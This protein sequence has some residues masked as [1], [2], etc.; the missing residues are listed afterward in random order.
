[1]SRFWVGLTGGIGSGKTTVANLFVQQGVVVVDTDV[2]AHQLTVAGG[3]AM[4]QI[5]AHFGPAL[6]DR[7]GALDRAAMRR[8][9]FGD[10]AQR[11]RLEDILH[12]MIARQTL[13]ACAS[14][15]SP[16][17]IV[18]VPL[19][20]EVRGWKEHFDRVLVIDCEEQQQIER[21]KARN[22]LSENEVRAI[23]A[24]QVSRQER[25][26]AAD[27]ILINSQGVAELEDQV[28]RLHALYLELAQKKLEA[29]C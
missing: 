27:D 29:E 25:L 10:P 17:V 20:L 8:L 16:Y 23:L 12:P 26:G 24:A 5:I 21:V 6:A 1:M 18:A 14:A 22:G 9:V 19:L 4:P 15:L 7:Q 13:Q 3:Q 28:R 2:I 11:Q